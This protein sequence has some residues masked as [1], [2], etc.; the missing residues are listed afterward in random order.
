MQIY[1]TSIKL[2]RLIPAQQ[3][4]AANE[5]DTKYW[6]ILKNQQICKSVVTQLLHFGTAHCEVIVK[7]IR[8]KG[9][10]LFLLV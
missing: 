10:L 2:I 8:R 4:R 9:H 5:I 1:C 7:I 6:K 3:N